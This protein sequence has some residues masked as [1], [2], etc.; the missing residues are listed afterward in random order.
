MKIFDDLWAILKIF[1]WFPRCLRHGGN[2]SIGR[3]IASVD[4]GTVSQGFGRPHIPPLSSIQQVVVVG[5]NV[6]GVVKHNGVRGG[7]HENHRESGSGMEGRAGRQ[8][9]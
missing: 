5:P 3:G 8:Q 2:P 4:A 7:R 1:G 9:D 6:L